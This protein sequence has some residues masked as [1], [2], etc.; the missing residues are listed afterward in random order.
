MPGEREL[1]AL[2][3][4][5]LVVAPSCDDIDDAELR[6]GSAIATAPDVLL[7]CLHLTGDTPCFLN[8]TQPGV[9]A[10]GRAHDG[11]F[12]VARTP[13][14]L[15]TDA[16]HLRRYVRNAE[17]D[18][19][20]L[21]T[22]LPMKG[23]PLAHILSDGVDLHGRTLYLVGFER[24]P[25]ND[26]GSSRVRSVLTAALADPPPEFGPMPENLFV[27]RLATPLQS[28]AGM[29]GGAV[30]CRD[31]TNGHLAVAGVI[32][33]TYVRQDAF[34]QLHTYVVGRRVR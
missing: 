23:Q 26:G 14:D 32:V 21:R 30:A 17:D 31:T 29:S 9:L 20:L 28:I 2:G 24:R 3:V 6:H 10:R 15:G 11:D 34:G 19:I 4:R 13:L 27:L 8:G 1:D 5:P 25:I 33:L 18:W 16:E 7:T 22:P 12:P